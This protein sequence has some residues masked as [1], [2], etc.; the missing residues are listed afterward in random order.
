MNFDGRNPLFHMPAG[1][2]KM[3]KGV[4]SWGWETVPLAHLDGRRMWYPQGRVLGGG[5]SILGANYFQENAQDDGQ[6]ILFT[7]AS[8]VFPY[9]LGQEGV[10][11]DLADKRVGYAIAIGPVVYAAPETGVET[12]ADLANELKAAEGARQKA[13]QEAQAAQK[14]FDALEKRVANEK[15]PQLERARQQWQKLLDE[16]AL[17]I[18]ELAALL[19]V[20]VLP[21]VFGSTYSI[22]AI[23]PGAGGVAAAVL[24]AADLGVLAAEPGRYGDYVRAVRREYE[25]LDDLQWRAG[26][27]VFVRDMLARDRIFPAALGLERTET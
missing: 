11:Y 25:H 14:A 9:L 12:A 23:F 2:A 26:R 6:M 24:L 7:T 20:R 1:F 5:G 17:R 22:Y 10:E 21:T 16:A 13:D 18:V 8:T 15:G 19:A 4:A 27:T 3:T